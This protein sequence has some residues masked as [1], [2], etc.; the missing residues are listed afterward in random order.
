MDV[1]TEQQKV[2][3]KY[4]ASYKE[5]PNGLK[6]GISLNV[7]NGCFPIHGLRHPASDTATGWYIWAGDYSN[8]PNFFQPLHVEHLNEWNPIIEKYLGLAPSWR[9]LITPNYEDVWQ[10]L[11]LLEV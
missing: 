2:C 1:I 3:K 4:K 9:F 11:S 8:A 6:V 10:D 5:S 7:K